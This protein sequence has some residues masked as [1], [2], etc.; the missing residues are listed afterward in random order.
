VAVKE[1]RIVNRRIILEELAIL[2]LVSNVSNIVKLIGLMGTESNPVIIYSYHNSSSYSNLSM[3]D[4]KWWLRTVLETISELHRLGIIH[5]D[6]KLANILTDFPN[7]KLAII[8]FGLSTFHIHGKDKDPRV[9]SIRSK[10]PE[11]AIEMRDYDCAADIWS[12]GIACLDLVLNMRHHWVTP[13]NSDLIDNLVTVFGSEKWNEF[14]SK[15]DD[16]FTV[17]PEPPGDFFEFT[18]PGNERLVTNETIDV[19]MKFLTLDP[20]RRISAHRALLLPFFDERDAAD[21]L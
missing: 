16:E 2:R 5:R 8:D 4:F 13:T 21:D 1:F 11:L 12:L 19:I 15:S 14:A 20:S 3:S 7:R 9:G 10:A 17:D 6:L 18:M